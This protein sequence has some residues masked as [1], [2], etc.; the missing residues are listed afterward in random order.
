MKLVIVDDHPLARQGLISMLSGE[1]NIQEVKEASNIEGAMKIIS[2]EDM[3]LAVIDLKLGHEDGLEIV[4]R[5]KKMNLKTKFVVLTSFIPQEDFERAEE[6][7]VD[8]YIL[9]D[10]FTEDILYAIRVVS[11][12]KK[13]Y[14]PEI[15][16][17]KDEWRENNLFNSLTTREKDVL[18]EIGKGLSNEEISKDLYISEHTVKKH[19]SNILA[20]L[21]LKHR[22]QIVFMMNNNRHL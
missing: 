19:V 11:R 4:A 9:K 22:S 10:A 18:K 3:E 17:N 12:G 21:N 16:R 20:K 7:G 5:G 2:N 13:Y 15:V 6:I 14:D 8:G 1:E